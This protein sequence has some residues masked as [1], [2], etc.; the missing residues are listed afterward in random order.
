MVLEGETMAES[1]QCVSN[2]KISILLQ[3]G[4]FSNVIVS[5]KQDKYHTYKAQL[6]LQSLKVIHY[7]IRIL[8]P[9]LNEAM[10]EISIFSLFL[11]G[12]HAK[13]SKNN[14][15][16]TSVKHESKRLWLT[17]GTEKKPSVTYWKIQ[18]HLLK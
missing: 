12:S 4:W 8:W 7:I 5:L 9:I 16:S 6:S 13:C 11:C 10:K 15:S 18:H 14:T 1:H 3:K 17:P 2:I